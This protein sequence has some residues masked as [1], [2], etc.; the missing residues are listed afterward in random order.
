MTRRPIALCLSAALLTAAPAV[1][2]AP[3][4]PAPAPVPALDFA[5]QPRPGLHTAGQPDAGQL[6][7]AAA[8]GVTTVID[9]RGEAEERGFDE[10]ATVQALGLRYLRLPVAG[11]EGVTVEAARQL[12]ALLAGADGPV[13]LHCASGNRAGA[14]LALAAAHVEGADNA[15]ALELGRAAGLGSL[16]PVVERQLPAAAGAPVPALTA[17]ADTDPKR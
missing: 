15:T 7:R 12:H 8:A 3:P 5:R 9:L 1:P 13:L 17:P 16:A 10:A 11:A 14:L 4:A 2:A 6:A